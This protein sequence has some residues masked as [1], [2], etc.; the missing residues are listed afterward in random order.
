MVEPAVVRHFSRA[1]AAGPRGVDL[2]AETKSPATVEA[3]NAAM[4]KWAEG[5]LK[6]IL[7]YCDEPIVSVDIAGDPHSS[8]F[9]AGCTSP[10]R[11]HQRPGSPDGS[12]SAR[13][14]YP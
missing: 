11:S 2:V 10:L 4:K 12:R 14:D 8:V 5:P 3:V 6:G 13:A 1:A 7:A 9:D